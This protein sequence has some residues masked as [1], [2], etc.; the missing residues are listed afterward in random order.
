M[1]NG[2]K[3][4]LNKMGHYKFLYLKICSRQLYKQTGHKYG[5]SPKR[6]VHAVIEYSWK[7]CGKKETACYELKGP[8]RFQKPSAADAWIW[9]PSMNKLEN[10]VIKREIVHYEKRNFSLLSQCFNKLVCYWEESKCILMREK[11]MK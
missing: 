11:E 6:K 8:Q 2:C 7:H 9:K 1:Q 10:I 5:K 4:I 3:Y